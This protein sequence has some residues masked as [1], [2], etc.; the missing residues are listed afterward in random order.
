MRERGEDQTVRATGDAMTAAELRG[1][2]RQR[3]RLSRHPARLVKH[4]T[5]YYP[6]AH[7]KQVTLRIDPDVLDW[8]KSVQG[9]GFQTRLN[10]A[11]R[12]FVEAHG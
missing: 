12:A 3:S 6:K 5:P 8:F 10:A 2:H 9:R 1:R 4:A 11:F 7:K